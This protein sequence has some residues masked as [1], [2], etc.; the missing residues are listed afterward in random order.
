MVVQVV[1][2]E[3]VVLRVVVAQLQVVEVQV[4]VII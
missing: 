2:E 3:L 1:D 4:V